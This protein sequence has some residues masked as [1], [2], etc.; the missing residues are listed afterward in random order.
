MCVGGKV[1]VPGAV[2]AMVNQCVRPTE[3]WRGGVTPALHDGSA[4]PGKAVTLDAQRFHVVG[5][6]RCLPAS[7]LAAVTFGGSLKRLCAVNHE[8]HY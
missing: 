8:C 6:A 3:S 5:L 2:Q 4:P 7:A 1:D